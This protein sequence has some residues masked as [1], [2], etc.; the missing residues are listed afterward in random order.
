[1]FV[2]E[3]D[4]I[5]WRIAARVNQGLIVLLLWE[6][7]SLLVWVYLASSYCFCGNTIACLFEYVCSLYPMLLVWA[8]ACIF[9]SLIWVGHGLFSRW[10]NKGNHT[11]R[12][13]SS[14]KEKMFPLFI[15][16]AQIDRRTG[17]YVPTNLPSHYRC[18]GMF[19]K[20]FS[21][22]L[23]CDIMDCSMWSSLAL[24]IPPS[25]Q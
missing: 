2:R 14:T 4:W 16:P 9:Q 22:F 24:I 21:L 11:R 5:F 15:G 18:Y 3:Y 7:H 8:L 12:T 19:K 10:R 25:A 1:M 13:T 6:Y 23:P 20:I 17:T